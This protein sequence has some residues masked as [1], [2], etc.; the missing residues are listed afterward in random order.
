MIQCCNK[1]I[2]ASGS[3]C[4]NSHIVTCNLVTAEQLDI[5]KKQGASAVLCGKLIDK[6]G[7]PIRAEYEDRM[8]GVDLEIFKNLDMSILVSA[9]DDRVEPMLATLKGR[10]ATH[11]VTN[12]HTAKHLIALANK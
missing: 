12:I 8:I 1:A 5:Y 2:F 6:N 3:C 7:T 10:Y 11:V 9:G 4:E